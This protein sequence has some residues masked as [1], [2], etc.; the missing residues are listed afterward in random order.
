MSY[1]LSVKILF[2][3]TP[4]EK[5][6]SSALNDNITKS[7]SYK[8]LGWPRS[9]WPR[10]SRRNKILELSPLLCTSTQNSCFDWN[11]LL[12]RL[13]I[14]LLVCCSPIIK[15]KAKES[16]Y[17][18]NLAGCRVVENWTKIVSLTSVGRQIDKF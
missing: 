5:L 1:Q 4:T 11:T 13:L 7:A 16:R 6:A 15:V 10:V 18:Q 3:I 17:T 9:C 14:F 2:F 8:L 12:V